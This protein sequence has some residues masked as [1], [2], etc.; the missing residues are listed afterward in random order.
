MTK[1]KTLID[2]FPGWDEGVGIFSYISKIKETDID[3]A[4]LVDNA[5][6]LDQ[7]YFGLHAGNKPV[8]PIFERYIVNDTISEENLNKLA[9]II[10]NRFGENWLKLSK[11]YGFEYN[12]IHNYDMEEIQTQENGKRK[13]GENETN[14]T[15]NI[16]KTR[17]PDLTETETPNITKTRT[18]EL[19][20]TETPNITKTRTPNITVTETPNI[21][22]EE[23]HGE[24]ITNHANENDSTY[25]FNSISAV[26]TDTMVEQNSEEHSG[27]D[28]SKETGTRTTQTTGT[29][30]E[31]ETGT[32]SKKYTGNE[33]ETETGTFS[34]KHTGNEKETEQGTI[35]TVDTTNET[36][37]ETMSLNIKRKGNIGVTTTQNM[38]RQEIDIWNW[39]FIDTVFKNVDKI[40]TLSIYY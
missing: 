2:Y 26:P 13:T 20:E 3:W 8:S 35:K 23:T 36:E 10:I 15:P 21:T 25:G 18:P 7:E 27:T 6:A 32:S 40:L 11:I 12:P 14:T 24:K 9:R 4:W 19:T 30:Q 5:I 33:K 1:K 22:N 31:T 38:I 17:T 37:N 39:N 28:V 34:R 29:E 16:T